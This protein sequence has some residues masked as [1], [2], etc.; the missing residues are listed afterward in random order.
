MPISEVFI[1]PTAQQLINI[2]TV[3]ARVKEKGKATQ[4]IRISPMNLSKKYKG[5]SQ[6]ALNKALELSIF[7]QA[8]ED[9]P[10]PMTCISPLYLDGTS[11]HMT[12][13][14]SNSIFFILSMI[15]KL[16]SELKG[17]DLVHSTTLTLDRSR[18][19]GQIEE[20]QTSMFVEC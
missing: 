9:N 6:D 15:E 18:N 8:E 7:L 17:N 3:N 10:N 13:S 16:K 12:D 5:W 20:S 14:M 4:F 19:H 2:V 11:L 1:T